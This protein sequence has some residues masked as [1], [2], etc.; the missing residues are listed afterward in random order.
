MGKGK[1][2]FFCS[3]FPMNLAFIFRWISLSQTILAL[4]FI[5]FKTAI[6]ATIAT[7]SFATRSLKFLPIVIV[8]YWISLGIV[9]WILLSPYLSGAY[10]YW[11]IF[12]IWSKFNF[13]KLL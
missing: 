7:G 5:I 12:G 8:F 3:T 10:Q 11:F 13:A 1:D 4:F 2:K 6:A 9:E